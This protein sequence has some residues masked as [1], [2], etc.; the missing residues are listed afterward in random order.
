VKVRI[1][2]GKSITGA[3]RYVMGPGHDPKTGHFLS[4]DSPSRV[5]WTG[6]QS[7]GFEIDSA[8]RVDVARKIMEFDA[9]HQA[10]K[11]KKC[12]YDCVHIVLAWERGE[13]PTREEMEEAARSHLKAQGMGN[14]K[15]VWVAHNDEDYFHLHIIASKINPATGNAYDLAGSWRKAS[16]WAEQYEREHGGIVNVNRE[17]ANELRRAI[18]ER[19]VEGVLAAMTKRNAHFT[20][21]KLLRDVG[22]EIHPEIGASDGKKRS[23]ELEKAQF[24]NA[25]LSHQSVRRLAEKLELPEPWM[26]V[27]GG[28]AGLS[29]EQRQAAERS[30]DSWCAR[31]PRQAETFGLAD[32]V[33][34]VQDKWAK[35]E[36][37]REAVGLRYTT[38]S[39]LDAEAHVLNAGN[40]LKT[41]HDHG[42]GEDRRADVLA[43]KYGTMSAEQVNAFRHCTGEEGLA[44]IDG[45]AGTGKSFTMAAIRD[46]YQAEGHRVIGLAFTRKVVGN[47]ARDGFDATTIHSQLRDLNNG[48]AQWDEKTV[49]M[50]DEA[51]M[52]GTRFMAVLAAHA[53]DAGAK[54]ILV[55]DDRQ[56]SSLDH[57][58]MFAELKKRHGAAVLSEVRRQY[59]ADERRASEMMHEGNWDAALA[60]YQTKGAIHWTRTQ[61]EARA[62][63]VERWAAQTAAGRDKSHFV[64]AYTN[65]D[66]DL[67]NVALRDVRKQ[68]GEL[69]WKDH[70]IKTAHGRFDFSA[71]DRVQFTGGDNRRG[72][73]NSTLGTILA[74]EGTHL[75]VRLDGP[76]GKVINFDAANFDK[77]RHGYAGTV[78]KGQGDTL[79]QTYLYHSEHWRS[80][81]SYVALT[82][83]REATS[84]FVAT[85]TAANLSVLA[86][87]VARQE[88]T[89]AAS[90]FYQ[91]DP[92][93]PVRPMTAREILAEF[94]GEEFQRTAERMER[95]GRAW[96]T[97]RAVSAAAPQETPVH[98]QQDN[99]PAFAEATGRQAAGLE[100]APEP[101]ISS[102]SRSGEKP[103]EDAG[104]RK[105]PA[106][107]WSDGTEAQPGIGQRI[108]R[109]WASW[110]GVA[111]VTV[112]TN[113]HPNRPGNIRRR[114]RRGH[115][116]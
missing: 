84:L 116:R 64:F 28:L 43:G 93:E 58:G 115:A 113:D 61:V 97:P 18:K 11:T 95:E 108:R 110:R 31:K 49:V 23:V 111:G 99:K 2:I 78:W 112:Q 100:S 98:R 56:I 1:K 3:V 38:R 101:G 59:K 39:I 24:V 88:E 35:E 103:A 6:G 36:H 63:L 19:D 69:E 85:N 73:V 92:I 15:A 79:D 72:I 48:R 55:G 71:G 10:S 91:L 86:K 8:A 21:D 30:Y 33:Q 83:H 62:A 87:Q 17:S 52:V 74:I 46:A 51:A 50:V 32:Y 16:V 9:Q 26:S 65:Q 13:T 77:F 34:Y 105:T 29:D 90:A 45:Q 66:V 4:S 27:T 68:R 94:A 75:A 104:Q 67:L 7:F 53:R 114:K 44:L 57:G 76:E 82:R 12:V 109:R 22:K 70:S 5:A 37:P 80:A 42:V 41:A 96:P 40:S 14:A 47:L 25:I 20:A 89:R 102:S 106:S 107:H 54:L 81:P 60:I